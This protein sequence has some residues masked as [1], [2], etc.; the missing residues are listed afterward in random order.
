MSQSASRLTRRLVLASAAASLAGSAFAQ[1]APVVTILG[2]SITAG[3]G[4]PAAG[5]SPPSSSRR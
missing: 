5:P 2:N 1:P 4:L 3:Y